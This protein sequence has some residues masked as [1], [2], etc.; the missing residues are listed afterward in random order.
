MST[1]VVRDRVKEGLDDAGWSEREARGSFTSPRPIY[2]GRLRS[3]A[4]PGHVLLANERVASVVM[5]AQRFAIA[6]PV[7]AHRSRRPG[8]QGLVSRP[9]IKTTLRYCRD[10]T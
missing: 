1:H 4:W 8:R 5:G 10:T 9:D 6:I 3:T 7:H 2:P